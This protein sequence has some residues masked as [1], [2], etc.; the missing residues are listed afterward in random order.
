MT[1]YTKDARAALPLPALQD[2][3]PHQALRGQP[4][5]QVHAAGVLP[6][7]RQE[8]EGGLM[9]RDN[10]VLAGEPPS[11]RPIYVECKFTF[12]TCEELNGGSRDKRIT[13]D[14]YAKDELYSAV[15]AAISKVVD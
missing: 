2:E 8:G 9:D 5:A 3:L 6:R 1:F 15:M 7:L 4:V 13:F 10:I 12:E 11:I 14:G